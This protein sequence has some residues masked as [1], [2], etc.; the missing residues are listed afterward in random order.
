M[1]LLS[2]SNDLVP[3]NECSSAKSAT[4]LHLGI[5]AFALLLSAGCG[6]QAP[7]LT[8]TQ[9]NAFDNAP[10]ETKQ[11]WEKALAA[12]KANDYMTA[13]TL[14][15]NLE[16]TTLSDPQKQ[17]LEVERANFG[18]RLVQAAEKN[19]PAAIKA[20]QS[21]GTSRNAPKNPATQ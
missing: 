9:T 16:Q 10:T 3:A 21:S 17:A 13:A 2:S 19:D 5:L 11:T 4:T 1:N 14:L 8:A 18:Q 20:L 15:N 7:K 6:N 12:D